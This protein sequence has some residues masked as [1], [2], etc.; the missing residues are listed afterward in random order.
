[1]AG[2]AIIIIQLFMYLLRPV[3]MYES[4]S[5]RLS[6]S[7]EVNLRVFGGRCFK[8]YFA[9]CVRNDSGIEDITMNYMNY[10]LNQTLLEL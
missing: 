2:G 10:F 1:V 9:Q 5:W 7:D 8:G 3:L 4:K 6:R